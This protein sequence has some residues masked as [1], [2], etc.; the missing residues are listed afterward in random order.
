M[1]KNAILVAKRK[2]AIANAVI[3]E[4]S[5]KIYINGKSLASFNESLF[6]QSISEPLELSDNAYIKYDIAIS[7]HGGGYN[8]R[9]QAVRAVVAKCLA[10]KEKSLRK[11]FLEYD[12][13]LL[14]DD[15]RQTEAQK[16]YRSAARALKQTSY[17]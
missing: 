11:K 15:K 7:L 12:R 9:A 16:P 6:K 1:K 13:T 4:G 17:R 3:K 10:K 14:V 2:T 8:A 5:G